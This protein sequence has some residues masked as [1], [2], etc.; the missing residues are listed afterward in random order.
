MPE[1]IA[2]CGSRCRDRR[3]AW[4]SAASSTATG[5][6]RRADA[7]RT[8]ARP[9]SSSAPVVVARR[10]GRDEQPRERCTLPRQH[11]ER[12]GGHLRD[13][14]R[15]PARDRPC[16][17]VG[18]AARIAA[19]AAGR[20]RRL[21]P[22]H[23]Q[24][25]LPARTERRQP[26]DA[27]VELVDVD[28]PGRQLLGRGLHHQP[29]GLCEAPRG[30]AADGRPAAARVAG[31]DDGGGRSP[32][33]GRDDL[34]R[35]RLQQRRDVQ[36]R[37]AQVGH[38]RE[39]QERS[40][41]R[42]GARSGLPPP[43]ATRLPARGGGPVCRSSR[44]TRGGAPRRRRPARPFR[45]RHRPRRSA[46]RQGRR[47]RD[48]RAVSAH[49]GGS[50]NS[51]SASSGGRASPSTR[52]RRSACGRIGGDEPS[53]PNRTRPRYLAQRRFLAMSAAHRALPR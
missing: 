40:R 20:D 18:D 2:R 43:R 11:L 46:G 52:S 1:G 47:S 3:S 19:R 26:L 5:T 12:V 17:S 50:R 13:D 28:L 39:P 14:R 37:V 33:D 36:V 44:R 21:E 42:A 22:G 7:R 16:Q 15:R 48:R 4:S 10:T 24:D 6:F 53:G 23:A 38:R 25:R 31:D 49:I 45:R 8:A 32:G 41:T 27:S 30:E 9:I 35:Q 34:A 51:S 29:A